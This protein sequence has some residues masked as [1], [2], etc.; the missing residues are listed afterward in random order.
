[1]KKIVILLFIFTHLNLNAAQS[2]SL[3]SGW[4]IGVSGFYPAGQRVF[5]FSGKRTSTNQALTGQFEFESQFSP[6]IF[7]KRSKE[8]SFV[9]ISNRRYGKA[10]FCIRLNKNIYISSKF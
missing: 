10:W 4:T 2:K 3:Q 8:N 7:I 1:M 9:I 5:E 6:Y